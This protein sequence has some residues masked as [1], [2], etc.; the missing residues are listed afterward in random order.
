MVIVVV[1]IFVIILENWESGMTPGEGSGMGGLENMLADKL[2]NCKIIL[3]FMVTASFLYPA[4]KTL[5]PSF[6]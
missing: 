4:D 3:R 5:F 1:L 6:I 2:Q